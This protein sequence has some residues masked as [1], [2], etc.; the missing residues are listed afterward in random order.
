[1]TMTMMN[2]S[3]RRSSR[4]LQFVPL[5]RCWIFFFVLTVNAFCFQIR[6]VDTQCDN[7]TTISS[8]S[9][10]SDA[11]GP[12]FIAN[13]PFTTSIGPADE[14]ADPT[15]R[16]HVKGRV[17]SS[18]AS[19]SSSS[20]CGEAAGIPQIRV[21]VWFAGT[22]DAEGNFYQSNE[23][24]GHVTTDDTGAYEFV[25]T[26][27]TL[28]PARPILH[29]HFRLSRIMYSNN[30]TSTSDAAADDTTED[31]T[32]LVTQLYFQ[33][34]DEG[35]LLPSQKPL[36]NVPVQLETDGSRSVT[37]DIYIMDVDNDNEDN[38]AAP[39]STSS[40]NTSVPTTTPPQ[41]SAASSTS[42]AVW[43]ALASTLLFQMIPV[44]FW[45]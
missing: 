18:R 40:P 24:R 3:T 26:F 34:Q 39:T 45:W 8:S 29:T 30:D 37:F 15:K 36:Q 13:T 44:V 21:E 10:P 33:G 19:S 6:M 25:Q 20:S 28:Y 16:L 38:N 14:L 17:L 4:M 9:T 41:T 5:K 12:F 2:R 1:M 35:F 43:C 22:P 27:P 31:T 23:Y 32:L 42:R 11:L 7:A